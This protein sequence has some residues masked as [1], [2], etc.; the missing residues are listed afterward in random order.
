[1]SEDAKPPAAPSLRSCYPRGEAAETYLM[2]W[3]PGWIWGGTPQVRAQQQCDAGL[4]D[5]Y[6]PGGGSAAGGLS[7]SALT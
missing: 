6:L 1:M 5:T 7:L 3:G 2:D 4:R